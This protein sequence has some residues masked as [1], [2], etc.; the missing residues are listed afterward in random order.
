MREDEQ[1]EPSHK[2]DDA[3]PLDPEERPAA[4]K[5]D[6]LEAHPPGEMTPS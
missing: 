1:P 2:K 4:P 5:T 3:P 6:G